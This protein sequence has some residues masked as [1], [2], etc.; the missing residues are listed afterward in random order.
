MPK[1]SEEHRQARRAQILAAARRRFAANGFHMTSMDDVIA[2]AGLSA[3]ALYRYF[4]SKNALILAC[5]EDAL[6]TVTSVVTE[7]AADPKG[8]TPGQTVAW[9]LSRSLATLGADNSRLGMLAW[10]ESLRNPEL[11]QLL[12]ER[13]RA[14]RDAMRQ[15]ARAWTDDDAEADAV[16]KTML[17]VVLGFLVQRAILGDVAEADLTAGLDARMTRDVR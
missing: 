17:S 7:L 11:H 8:R 16:A 9:I 5:A 10:T 1:V 3:G 12:A 2:E 6:D 4:P 13:Y 14:I 15:A